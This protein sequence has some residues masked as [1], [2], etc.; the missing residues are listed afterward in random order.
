MATAATEVDVL[1]VGAGVLGI[2]Q[3]YLAREAG[4]STLVLEAAD[5]PG[6]VWHWNRY[7]EARLD[8][9]SFTYGYFFDRALFE[10][11]E[12]KE[13]F[14]GQPENE[15]YFQYVVQKTG[16][17]ERIRYG[18]RVDSAVWDEASGRWRVHAGDG[19]LVS[20]RYLVAATG[21]LSIPIYP[22]VEGRADFRG[23]AHHTGL[24]PKEPVDFAGKRVAVFGVGSSGVQVVPAVADDAASVTVYQRTPN[25]ATPLNNQRI[26]TEEYAGIRAD[27]DHIKEVCETSMSGYMHEPSGKKT[28][29]DDAET[30]RAFYEEIWASK[31]FAKLSSNYTDLL[32]DPKANAEWC[33]FMADKIRELVHDPEVA[34]KLIPDH[35]YAAKRPPFVTGYYEA[36]NKPNVELVSIKEHPVVR[37]T[38][39]GIETTDGHRE[40]DVI[41]W[42]S[43]FDFGTGALNRMGIV[44]RDGLKLTEHWKDG[45]VTFGGIQ[46][47][48]FPN[49]FFPG[50]PHGAAGNNP[51][52]GADQI[53]FV[54]ALLLHL[55]DTG[56]NVVEVTEAAQ[57]AWTA[58]VDQ[59]AEYGPFKDISYFFG[60][61]VPGKPRRYLLNA[62]GKP[63]MM[64]SFAEAVANDHQGYA[65]STAGES[66]PATV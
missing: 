44:G 18:A 17:D 65:I 53:N 10:G 59:M 11:W 23:V 52:Y 28:F 22:P 12:W 46:A 16:L 5:G 36:F 21:V 56:R 24:W 45:P 20:A 14:A 29:D 33:A 51:R 7:P 31:G 43:G 26:S 39:T 4:F 38:E 40:F 35:P 25:W 57:D 30:R 6:G 1:V 19:S 63:K 3:A 9:E 42:A 60:G 2:Y 34:E 47:H 41:V 32:T 48:G 61:N 49:L 64:E 54:H 37:V 50:G 62:A 15:A 66:A 13:Y 8:S 27:F 58:T 55:R